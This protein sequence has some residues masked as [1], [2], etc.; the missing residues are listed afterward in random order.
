MILAQKFAQRDTVA[1]GMLRL[2]V[3]IILLSAEIRRAGR[4][5]YN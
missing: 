3:R 2:V 5:L 1:L 4:D